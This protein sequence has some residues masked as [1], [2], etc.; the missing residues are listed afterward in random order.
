MR[1]S[2]IHIETRR[3]M[4]ARARTDGER[5]LV[6]AGYVDSGGRLTRLGELAAARLQAAV[7][8]D[9][10]KWSLF[11]PAHATSD[12]KTV[13]ESP[14]GD[15]EL[16]RCAACGYADGLQT[17]RQRKS[18]PAPE[19]P[20]PLERVATPDCSTIESLAEF[21]GIP[22]AKTAKA[23]LYV[24]KGTDQ[25]VFVVVRGDT[26]AS[27]AKLWAAAG[28]L[29]AASHDQI[30]AAGVVPGYASPIDIHGVP[31]LVDDLI[32]ISPNLVAGA[33]EHGF[34]LLNTNYGR[35]YHAETVTDL[36]LTRPGGACPE[37]GSRLEAAR[38][39][40]V[41]DA[42]V[43]YGL[44]ALLCLAERHHDDGGLRLPFGLGAFDVYLLHLPSRGGLTAPAAAE[45]HA[46]L[47]AGGLRVLYDDRDE[48]AGVKFNDADLIGCPVRITVGEKH[49]ND[50]MVELKLRSSPTTEIVPL[51]AIMDRIHS[52]SQM[53]Q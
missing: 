31:I 43:L 26:Q 32:P 15:F 52:L 28:E 50:R 24:R 40:I 35:D 51:D 12:G 1:F 37:C 30:A 17:A 53:V 47:D 6:R 39:Y 4:P 5:Y 44:N 42:D 20:R 25:L 10:D 49:L 45:L 38:G 8:A 48:R 13:V 3:E 16:L 33:N 19:P 2:E 21:L 22:E 29:A 11:G 23:L 34:H 14:T 18:A 7:S 41:A 9:A 46:A 36:T 27:E